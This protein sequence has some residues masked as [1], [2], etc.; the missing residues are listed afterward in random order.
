MYIVYPGENFGFEF[1]PNQSDLFRFIPKSVS[2]L[3]R[4]D[5]EIFFDLWR[6]IGHANANR[7]KIHQI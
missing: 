3:I 4:V 1:I 5:P 6:R 7:L 2:E